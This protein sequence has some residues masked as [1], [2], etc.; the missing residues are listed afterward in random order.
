MRVALV[1]AFLEDRDG[2]RLDDDFMENV[3]CQ[4]DHFYHRYAKAL[5][6]KN[7]EPI[8]HMMSQEKITKKFTH[9]YGHTILRIPA[10]RIPFIHEPLV[11][12][13][14]LIQCLR[15]NFDLCHII[16]GYYV[17]YKV[18]DMFDY[19]VL[20]LHDKLPILARWA[21]GKYDWL[22]PGR[23]YIKKLA[24]QRCEKIVCS[25]RKETLVLQNKF[26]IPVDRIVH[27]LNPI[28]LSK[29]RKR[30]KKEAALKLG[31][32]PE[33]RYLLFVGR[34][35][36]LKGVWELLDVFKDLSTEYEDLKLIM[37]GDGPLMDDIPSFIKN[38]SMEK[39]IMI[40]GRLTHDLLPYYY[41]IAEALVNPQNSSAGGIGNVTIEAMASEIPVV[42][43][44]VDGRDEYISENSGTGI[45]VE[46]GN[47]NSL[48]DG[49][50]RILNNKIK[51][52]KE[53]LQMLNEFSY[54]NFGQ[55]LLN[56]YS[57]VISK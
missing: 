54:D 22:F 5:M 27:L 43:T 17:M 34:M 38:N 10:I 9:K 32:D 31:I 39:K 35:V 30:D 2:E 44:N 41:N 1:S 21:G 25:S 20:K 18:P 24:L 4:E 19:T 45:L 14:Q 16:S 57:E 42:V 36:K 13:S 46:P 56:I 8:L 7:I 29:F 55:K 15:E 47:K 33:Y 26:K 48:K 53:C 52:N 37:I 50:V 40:K 11:Y 12:S 49:I 51:S 23:R 28:D 6:D 3:V